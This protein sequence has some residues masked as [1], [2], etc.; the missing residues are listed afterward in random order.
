[1]DLPSYYYVTLHDPNVFSVLRLVASDSTQVYNFY[2]YLIECILY[3]HQFFFLFNFLLSLVELWWLVP[4]LFPAQTN[5]S[6]YC[7]WLAS[8]FLILQ[9]VSFSFL[10]RF[11][12]K[13]EKSKS[14]PPSF[15]F[16][17]GTI[18][19]LSASDLIEQSSTT[20]R[21]FKYCTCSGVNQILSD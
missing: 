14:D 4:R 17:G 3:C 7:S 1:M 6:F 9:Q 16:V 11:C 2:Y 12:E 13:M 8:W 21:F 5:G 15:L 20:L 19:R 18:S 10:S